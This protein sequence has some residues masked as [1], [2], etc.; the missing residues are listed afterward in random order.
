MRKAEWEV[1]TTYDIP[2]LNIS[3]DGGNE[4]NSTSMRNITLSPYYQHSLAMAAVYTLAYL[5][6]FL[7]CMVGNGL[8]CV[9]VLRNHHMRTVTNLFILNLAISDLLVGIFCIPTTLVDNLI[10]GRLLRC[11]F[12]CTQ[13]VARLMTCSTCHNC[14]CECQAITDLWGFQFLLHQER[15]THGTEGLLAS[16]VEQHVVRPTS[17][18]YNLLRSDLELLNIPCFVPVVFFNE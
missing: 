5:F 10:T 2:D 9:I 16:S 12:V 15:S 13:H 3:Y 8:V 4:S 17:F 18:F 7:L 14:C 1:P 6:I 11:L